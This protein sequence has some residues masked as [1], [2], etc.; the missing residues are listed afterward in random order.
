LLTV[1]IGVTPQTLAKDNQTVP[2][3]KNK[4]VTLTGILYQVRDGDTLNDLAQTFYQSG[5]ELIL[6]IPANQ[7][8]PFLLR[9][10]SSLLIA[11][12][13][14][15]RKYTSFT[16][17]SVQG[18]YLDL[19]ASFIYVRVSP[20][21]TETDLAWYKQTIA[22]FNAG[23]GLDLSTIIPANFPLLVPSAL[24]NSQSTTAITYRVHEGDTLD[25]VARYFL[26]LQNR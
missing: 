20:A 13:G 4:P 6:S 26:I 16:Y 14:E 15:G 7:Q 1:Q 24:N 21:I 5:P 11:Q 23:S 12:P 19:L 22:D 9:L 25:L 10:E 2:L 3:Q 18:D 8:N 17:R